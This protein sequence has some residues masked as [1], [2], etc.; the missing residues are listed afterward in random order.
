MMMDVVFKVPSSVWGR[1]VPRQRAPVNREHPSAG[2]IGAQ[3]E[4]ATCQDGCVE[5]DEGTEPCP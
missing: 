3:F 5:N 4:S 1:I 2:S